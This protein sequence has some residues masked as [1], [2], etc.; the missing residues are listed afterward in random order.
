MFITDSKLMASMGI[1]QCPDGQV[2][3]SNGCG[4]T[5]QPATNV[6]TTGPVAE[7]LTLDHDATLNIDVSEDD[8]VNDGNKNRTVHESD[9]SDVDDDDGDDDECDG[10]E[11]DD[12]SFCRY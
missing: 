6:K 12:I 5:C 11:Y 8:F 1:Q 2:C 4:H 10:D 9:S 3:M 7:L